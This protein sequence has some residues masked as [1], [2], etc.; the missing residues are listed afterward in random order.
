MNEM[1]IVEQLQATE[2]SVCVS[3]INNIYLD[4]GMVWC[5]FLSVFKILK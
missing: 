5:L 1:Q 4:V 3:S 2:I